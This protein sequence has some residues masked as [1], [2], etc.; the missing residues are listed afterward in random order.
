MIKKIFVTLSLS[1]LFLNIFAEKTGDAHIFG[2][3]IDKKTGEHAPFIN[4]V[5]Q[6]TTIGTTTDNTGHYM[7][8]NLPVG[9]FTISAKGMG[10]VTQES[11]VEIQSGRSFELNFEIEEDVLKLDEVIVTAGRS[12]QKRIEAPVMVNTISTKKLETTHS[13]V[14]GEGLNFCTG[15]RYENNCQ[16][17]GFSQV[18][19]N[20]LEGAYSQILINSRP[21]F[22][23]LAGVYGLELIPANMLERI[24]I[25]RGGGSVLYGSSAIAGTINLILK[26]PKSNSFEAG[27]SSSFVGLGVDGAPRPMVDYNVNFS[28]SLVTN[29]HRCGLSVYGNM[30]DRGFFDANGDGFS[31]I[32][33]MKNTVFGARLFHRPSY[34]SKIALD[35][36]NI[37]E[38]RNGGNDVDKPHHEREVSESVS[39]DMKAA[40]LTFEQYLR[41]NDV[42]S[43]FTSGQYLNRDS[44]YGAN[45]SLKDYGNSVDK[46]YNIGI[47]YKATFDRSS[48]V[49]GVEHTG[50]HLID[51]KL[52][53]P[54]YENALIVNDSIISVP[55]EPNTIVSDQSLTTA[56]AFAQYEIKLGKFKVL[57]GARVEHYNVND[58]ENRNNSNSNVVF[59]PRANLMYDIF[60]YLQARLGYSSGYRAPQIFD[61]DLHIET[62]G[63][64]KV[65]NVNDPNLKQENS[66][67]YTLSVD[68]NKRLGKINA[69]LLVEGFYTNLH[70]PFRN[71]MGEVDEH[72]TVVY[73]RKNVESGAVVKGMNVELKIFPTENTAFT[74]GF[75]IQSNE[76]GE[77]DE[78]FGKTRFFRTPSTYGFFTFDWDLT[79]RVGLSTNGNYTGKMLIPYFGPNIAE[80]EEGELRESKNFFDT[81]FKL[82]YN[83]SLGGGVIAQVYGGMKNVFNSYQSDFD[84]TADRDPGYIYGPTSPRTVFVG[85]KI[86]L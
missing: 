3:V 35:F 82:Y 73:E 75:T 53:Y 52:A 68:F 86:S 62:S 7:L 84:K 49:G 1:F 47:Q 13:L 39:H 74:G 76:Y 27:T 48:F 6:G 21:I 11:S 2:H 72:G 20:G 58:K 51:K 18:R 55:H 66:S 61:E 78:D 36:F 80:P 41:E 77:P 9:Q 24:E 34:R 54:N 59:V 8:T 71:E 44:Y 46:T 64:R 70:N 4:I 42:L 19:M 45:Y 57:A 5:I 28:A 12:E 63:S 40:A 56:G 79:K 25:V 26:D 31:E 33:P 23:G 69:G 10:Y 37:A 83:F 85:L 81:D 16:N 67:S 32:S 22:S 50:S 30:R 60:P 17:C 29:D 65:V 43:V 15:L 38:K 14:L